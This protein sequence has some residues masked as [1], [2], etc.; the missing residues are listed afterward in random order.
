MVAASVSIYKAGNRSASQVVSK[1][2]S[3]SALAPK[4]LKSIES[5]PKTP[6]PYTS[7]EAL[8]LYTNGPKERNCNIYLS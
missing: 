3:E 6:I 5:E 7:E 1:L 8:A 2:F 4:M